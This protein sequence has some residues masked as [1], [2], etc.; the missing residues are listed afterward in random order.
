MICAPKNE[1]ANG[2]EKKGYEREEILPEEIDGR[3]ERGEGERQRKERERGL[4]DKMGFYR[5][6]N[7]AVYAHG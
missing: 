6:K 1:T 3:E 7:I 4:S 5:T 2:P